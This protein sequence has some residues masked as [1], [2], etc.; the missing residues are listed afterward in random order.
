MV[1]RVTITPHPGAQTAF[2]TS[3]ADEVC[4]GGA[5]GGGKSYGLLA[6]ALRYVDRPGY[7]ALLLRT[8]FPELQMSL[9]ETALDLLGSSVAYNVNDHLMRFPSGARVQFG[10]IARDAHLTRYQSAEFAY[11]GLDEATSFTKRQYEWLRSRN[12]NVHGL[13]NRMRLA[14]NPGGR[15]H[16]WVKTRFVDACPPN[17]VRWFLPEGDGERQVGPGTV[18]AMSREWIPARVQ[19]NPTLMEADPGYI[20]R[21]AALPPRDRMMLLEGSWTVG[22]EGLVYDNYDPAVHVVDPFELDPKWPRFRSID[23]GYN[24]PFVCQWY[25]LTPDDVLVLYREI[26]ESHRLVSDLGPEIRKRTGK[27]KV[28]A[29][30]ADHDAE[31]RAELVRSGIKTA[32]AKKTRLDGMQ[33]VYRRMQPDAK[34]GKPRL[35]FFRNCTV[36]HDPRMRYAGHPTSTV[37]EILGYQFKQDAA[38]RF[39]RDEPQDFDNHGMDALRYMCLG[40]ALAEGQRYRFTTVEGV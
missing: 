18:G 28:R 20:H 26:Y 9:I 36:T 3:P 13:P 30:V 1:A 8:T 12:R 4:Y 37:G 7:H 34:T 39:L 32:P 10:F 21:L 22:Y 19:D 24:N 27:E 29:T 17:A 38:G 6:D 11:I 31:N 16:D 25:C 2:L 40:I 5:A 33:A 14:T 23:F 15:G 35:L